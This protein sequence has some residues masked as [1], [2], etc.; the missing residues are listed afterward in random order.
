MWNGNMRMI[1]R[2]PAAAIFGY[3]YM[4]IVW[5]AALPR[6]AWFINFL[7]AGVTV[8]GPWTTTLRVMGKLGWKAGKEMS[9]MVKYATIGSFATFSGGLIYGLFE[10]DFKSGM[11]TV[12]NFCSKLL[13]GQ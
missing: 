4:A 9:S 1:R 13:T 8:A 12:V 3:P 11:S 2:F 10:E 7:L 5:N 6:Q